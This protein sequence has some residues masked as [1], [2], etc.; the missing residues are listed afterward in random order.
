LAGWD[1]S[2]PELQPLFQHDDFAKIYHSYVTDIA[3][4][5]FATM[6]AKVNDDVEAFQK[7]QQPS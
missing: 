3:N 2:S 7:S 5:K 4:K 6:D 1:G